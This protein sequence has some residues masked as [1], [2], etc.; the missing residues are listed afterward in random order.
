MSRAVAGVV[1]FVSFPMAARIPT[2]VFG[3]AV[4]R[5]LAYGHAQGALL[6]GLAVLLLEDLVAG[7]GVGALV[8]YLAPLRGRAGVSRGIELG[9]G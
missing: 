9:H 7:R 2:G 5:F 4:W 1:L 3:L 6:V 8:L